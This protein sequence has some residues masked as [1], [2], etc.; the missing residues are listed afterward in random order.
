MECNKDEAVRAK[1]LAEI[2]MQ[3]GQFVEAL[4]FANK[5]KKMYAD[6]D[7]IAQILAI[8]EVHIAALNKLSSSEMDWY[9]ILQTERLSKEEIIKKQYKKLALLLHP[10]KNKFGGA[11]AAFK[12]IGEANSVLTDQ[13]KRSLHDAKVKAHARAEVPKTPSQT[14]RK[15][16]KTPSQT[17]HKVPK[18]RSHARRAVYEDDSD[19]DMFE[20]YEDEDMFEVYEDEE[21]E[22]FEVYDIIKLIFI[23]FLRL[24]LE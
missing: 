14:R 22:L 2:R 20:V 4:K 12:L 16:P 19:E 3:R 1:Q 10:D 6:V 18:T 21:D 7:N 24:F 11:E 9:R 13:A 23:F 8:C 15:V 17:R 5:A